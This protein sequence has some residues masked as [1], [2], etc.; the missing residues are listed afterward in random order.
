M[1]IKGPK[2]LPAVGHT[3]WVAIDHIVAII[4]C[5][6]GDYVAELSNGSN[7]QIQEKV[8]DEYIKPTD[9][10]E[11]PYIQNELP[12]TPKQI[13]GFV[14]S[15]LILEGKVCESCGYTKLDDISLPYRLEN[16]YKCRNC[17]HE[18]R[19]VPDKV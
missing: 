15:M 14:D 7:A 17:G 12:P 18:K 10:F 2:F 6:N 8:W 9:E 16:V 13:K 5:A 19:V 4:A 3:R 1:E 11:K